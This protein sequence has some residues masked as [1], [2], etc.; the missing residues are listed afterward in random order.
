LYL[1]KE[2]L[3]RRNLKVTTKKPVSGL[4]P[5]LSSLYFAFLVEREVLG[6]DFAFLG[7]DFNA[8][9]SSAILISTQISCGIFYVSLLPTLDNL[10]TVLSNRERYS[11]FVCWDVL[12]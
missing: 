12:V 10:L 3:M 9:F 2:S 8:N 7:Q 1:E 5:R 6:P 11:R 4:Y